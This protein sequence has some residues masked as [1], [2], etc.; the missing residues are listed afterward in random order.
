MNFISC[1]VFYQLLP[2]FSDKLPC[3]DA[4]ILLE[5][6]YTYIIKI[7]EWNHGLLIWLHRGS[8]CIQK[9]FE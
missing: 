2:L 1:D 9:Q 3:F 8:N 6:G 4:V 7:L 5:W